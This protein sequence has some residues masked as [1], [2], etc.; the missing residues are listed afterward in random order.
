MTGCSAKNH[1]THFIARSAS[2]CT[3]KNMIKEL[4]DLFARAHLEHPASITPKEE[5][6]LDGCEGGCVR[7]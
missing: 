1:G 2:S 3:Q 6:V 4:N 7:R 5:S